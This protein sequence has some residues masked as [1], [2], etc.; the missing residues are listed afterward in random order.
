MRSGARRESQIDE[1]QS[2]RVGFAR[3]SLDLHISQRQQLRAERRRRARRRARSEKQ[4][5]ESCKN[6]SRSGSSSVGGERG[7]SQV[8]VV[9]LPAREARRQQ[10]GKWRLKQVAV[11][12]SRVINSLCW[13]NCAHLVVVAGR[14]VH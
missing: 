13:H 3:P 10:A 4:A 14:E 12:V 11:R 5:E 2:S 6:E 9:T 7:D 8:V 1:S